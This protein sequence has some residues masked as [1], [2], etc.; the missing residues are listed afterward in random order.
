MT[1]EIKTQEN[2]GRRLALKE[3][4]AEGKVVFVDDLVP[5]DRI[6]LRHGYTQI[7]LKKD[8]P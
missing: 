1:D 6:D 2:E 4:V 8:G 3:L 7:R 5:L